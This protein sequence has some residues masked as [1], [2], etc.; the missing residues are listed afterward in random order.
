VAHHRFIAKF[1]VVVAIP[2]PGDEPAVDADQELITSLREA[3]D[4][5]TVKK[6][7]AKRKNVDYTVES[8]TAV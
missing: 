5:A 7:K 2:N 1:N 3:L 6:T 4:K 8:V